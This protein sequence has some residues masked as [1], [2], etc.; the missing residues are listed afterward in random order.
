MELVHVVLRKKLKGGFLESAIAKNRG[1]ELLPD[2]TSAAQP[3]ESELGLD[4]SAIAL[5]VDVMSPQRATRLQHEKG[6]LAV[7]L[8]IPM[9]LIEPL[10]VA[11]ADDPL[12]DGSTWGIK[13]VR[14]DVSTLTGANVVVA[15][16][17]TGIDAT[18]AAFAGVQIVPRNFTTDSDTDVHGHGTHCAGTIF[19]ADVAGIRIGIA[20][21]VKKALIG[22]VLGSDGGGSD[23]IARAIQW[24]IEE[25]AHVISMSL[26]ID[27]PGLVAKLQAKGY[28]VELATSVALEGYRKN[29][30]LFDSL[31][32]LATARGLFGDPCLLIAAAGNESRRDQEQRFEI[33]VSPPAVAEGV[34]SVAALDRSDEGLRIASFSNTGAIVAGPG[35]GVLSAKPGGGLTTKSGT[36]MATPH[37]A[38]VAALWAEKL[39]SQNQF[40]M[41][42]FKIRLLAS[43]TQEGLVDGFDPDDVGSGIVGAP[44]N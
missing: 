7:A 28:P 13:A 22:K 33:A 31:A 40:R 29:V 17:D 20:R 14:A 39:M 6:V 44:P 12:T 37:V 5:D 21:G 38:G 3:A 23:T 36:S 11:A 2:R 15:V 8:A 41:P 18:H 16:L 34:I 32:S 27:F 24:A 19:G 25:G 42:A 9:K 43:A 26:G 1:R 35:V 4:P 30:I 10:D